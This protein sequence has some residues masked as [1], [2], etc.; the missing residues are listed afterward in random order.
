MEDTEKDLHSEFESES[1]QTYIDDNFE[2]VIEIQGDIETEDKKARRN[3]IVS[4]TWP[5]LAE[6]ILMSLMQMADM[7]MVGGLGTDAIAGVGLV[8]QPRF[9]MMSAF[10]ALNIGTTALVAR[11]RGARDQEGATTAFCQALLISTILTAIIGA[12]MLY[13]CEPLI[14]FVA[15][16]ELSEGVIREGITYFRIQIY[17]IPTM[18]LTMCMNA[19]LRGAGNTRAAFYNN[20]V[21]NTINVF[22]NYCLIFG[23]LGF[24]RMGVAGASLATVI[25]QFVGLCMVAFVVAGGKYYLSFNLKKLLRTDLSMI[26]RIVKIGIP[27]LLEQLIMRVGSIWFT[28]IATALGDMAYAAHMIAM[29]IQM[30]SWTSGMAFGVAATTLVGQCLGRSRP[31]LAKEY[32]R[33]TQNLGYFVSTFIGITL[34]TIGRTL[35]GLYSTDL[36]IIGLAADMLRIVALTNPVINARLVYVSALRGAGDARFMAVVTFIGVLLVRPL[37][38]LLLTRVFHMGL[39]GLW[40]ALVTDSFICYVITIVRYR[41]GKW[42][43]IKV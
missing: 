28:T 11:C 19:A 12:V 41:Q 14:R 5:S 20:S 1:A 6:N 3:L 31:D 35:S 15:G 13:F 7:M 38:S 22:L 2:E 34:F 18:S 25:G 24:P 37:L 43:S 32:V 30:L 8:S 26:R 29:N 36:I 17:G 9:L 16:K 27:A 21:A 39:T 42:V 10:Q 33:M 40:I 23:N 4:L